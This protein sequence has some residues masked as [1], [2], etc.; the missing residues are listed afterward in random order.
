[1]R[2]IDLNWY[3]I[4]ALRMFGLAWDVKARSLNP[5]RD[6]E[7]AVLRGI[8]AY[9]TEEIVLDLSFLPIAQD[10]RWS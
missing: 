2:G 7:E 5:G 8:A 4:A 3:A 9:S 1:M 10:N 6:K